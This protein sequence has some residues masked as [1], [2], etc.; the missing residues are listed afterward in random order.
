M[1]KRLSYANVMA[2]V[3]VFFAL[4]GGAWAATSKYL[5]AS[6]PIAQG[7]LAGSTYGNPVIAAGKV[8]SAKVADG[9]LTGADI[10]DNSIT[11]ADVNEASLSGV[12]AAS[13]G[14]KSAAQIPA[15]RHKTYVDG[16][17]GPED[18]TLLNLPGL[19]VLATDCT[20]NSSTVYLQFQAGSGGSVLYSS[21][22]NWSNPQ[23]D[24]PHRYG[25]VAADGVIQL[26]NGS[27]DPTQAGDLI[28]LQLDSA[29]AS[30]AVTI[31][32]AGDASEPAG[33]CVVAASSV[34][35]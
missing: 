28:R 4:T 29:S 33:V 18:G 22:R 11:G 7:D 32:V 24:V 8:T 1:R 21:N 13:V 16:P 14:G 25:G 2:T 35:A 5:M 9:S 10:Q 6:D 12:D 26:G 31:I 34:G 27:A 15:Y 23:L 19:G 30:A 3:A 20:T 17:G